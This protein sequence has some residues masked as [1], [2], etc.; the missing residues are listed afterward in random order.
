[1][2]ISTQEAAAKRRLWWMVL[3]SFVLQMGLAAWTQSYPYDAGCFEAWSLRIADLGPAEFYG[4]E[5]FC[6][7][8]PGYILMSWLPGMLLKIV[9]AAAEAV[10]RMVIAFWPSLATALC[11]PVVYRFARK[12]TSVDWSM[13][14][15]A[16]A[17]FCPA[18]LFNTGV[19]GQIDGVFALAILGGFVLLEEKRWLPGAFCFGIGLV[20]KPQALLVGP[21]L[22][23]CFLM[24][25]LFGKD[26]KERL[27]G[28]KTGVLGVVA[29]LVPVLCCGVLFWG[30]SDLIPGLMSKYFTT[31][32]SY[33][34]GTI[35]AA[36]LIAFLGG[37][38][39][40]QTDPVMLFGMPLM[41]W[42][43]L[44]TMLLV[45]VTVWV[46]IW[47]LRAWKNGTFSPTLTAAVYAVCVFTFGHRMHERY[48]IFAL[49]LLVAAAARFEDRALLGI[50]GGFTL[51]SLFN[52]A[53]VYCT[54][55]GEDEFL[56]NALNSFM[57]K[58]IG[59]A[60]TVL[61]VLLMYLAWKR[62]A[63]VAA[64][65]P[66]AA[67]KTIQPTN[68]LE[69]TA[70]EARKMPA[71]TR[72]EA[73]ALV[74]L[75][76]VTALV[77]FVYLGDLTAPQNPVDTNEREPVKYTIQ[78]EGTPAEIW[79][80]PGISSHNDGHFTLV[81][82]NGMT[83]VD[84]AL[85][86]SNPF[87][88]KQFPL[89]G[90]VGPYTVT[91]SNGQVMEISLRDSENQPLPASA[92]PDCY[93]LD[94][95]NLVPKKISQLNS[96][97]FDEIYHARTGY[98]H[99]HK[100]KV[101]ETTHPPMGKNFIAMGIALFGMT[102]FGWRF[103]GTLF[104]VLMVPA[105]YD[106]VRRLTHKPYYAFFAASL[107]ALD[108]MRFSQS[109]LATIDSYV[110]LFILLGADMMLWYCQS[111]LEKGVDHSILPMALGGIAFGFGC[112]SK[113]TGL[114]AGA[115]LAVLYFGVLWRRSR[116]LLERPG[117]KAKERC[118]KEVFV[119]LAGG[120]VFF[121]VVPLLIYWASYLPYVWRNPN[122]GFA[123]WWRC[124]DS[125]YWY[126]STLESTHPFA[127]EWYTWPL[128][129]RPV[130]YY[131]AK[132]LPENMAASIAGFIS[133]A[134][135]VAGVIG[136]LM[137]AYRQMVGRGSA[138]GGFI[139]VVTLSSLLPW[140][141]VSRCT[142][143]YHFFPCV[144]MLAAAAALVLSQWEDTAGSV[145]VRRWAVAILA[146]ALVLF[147]WFYPVLSGL[148][149]PKWWASTL[150]LLPT[151]GFYLL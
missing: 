132:Q 74:G 32:T 27:Q 60:T 134:L 76:A 87:Q 36:N 109:R 11:G 133:P 89:N 113:W 66:K 67:K 70:V 34:Y 136:W 149:I 85:D 115:G 46:F 129:A 54:V 8:P 103:F 130:W 98:E 17:M 49:V 128:N 90:A 18:L 80:Y 96:F 112:A 15:A 7:Y 99:L 53:L 111:V 147:A 22:A 5:Y 84:M 68:Q 135:I 23:I 144:P 78:P 114:Y 146:A 1:M 120:V 4:S 63:P 91:I 20:I 38:W 100:M 123:D 86:H 142:F 143:L 119:A 13:R 93:L 2:G 124:Q 24:P 64:K 97:Y 82:A 37:E 45:L 145:K 59:L 105:L 148:P 29:A 106:L 28:F 6:D 104:G 41:S 35:N 125:M 77:S 83:Q 116:I 16:A 58:N 94:E 52:M 75:T 137:L 21:V 57:L 126:H 62:S 33:P 42:Q 151:W 65:S 79:V 131:S 25:I 150:E 39:K 117:K 69:K 92:D 55:G 101:Y 141:L 72:K 43:T 122:F 48:M 51:T 139:L 9:P 12:H 3:L 108:F 127:S 31:T 56:S 107:L 88:W 121:V 26:N 71:W 118:E 50:S 47:S 138:E 110:V 10:R 44:G 30:F 73:L 40:P 19:W 95:Q 81:D 61:C 102:G 140:V 14:C